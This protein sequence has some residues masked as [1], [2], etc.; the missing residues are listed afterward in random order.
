MTV[1]QFIGVYAAMVVVCLAIWA[2]LIYG[3]CLIIR[4]VF[5]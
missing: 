5:A 1:K 2:G 4:S 3:A